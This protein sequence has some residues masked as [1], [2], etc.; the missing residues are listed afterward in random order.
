MAEAS[1]YIREDVRSQGIG[2]ALLQKIAA[3]SKERGFW[4]IVT[5]CRAA[6]QSRL[7]R[8]GHFHCEIE[9]GCVFEGNGHSSFRKPVNR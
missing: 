5:P 6:L 4:T 7:P 8:S 1:V 9:G 2:T 3:E